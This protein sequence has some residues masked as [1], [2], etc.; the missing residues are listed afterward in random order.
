MDQIILE[1]LNSIVNKNA[2][3]DDRCEVL[4]RLCIKWKEIKETSQQ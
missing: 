3:T 4:N 2:T 1:L